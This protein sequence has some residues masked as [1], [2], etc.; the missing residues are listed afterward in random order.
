MDTSVGADQQRRWV[1]FAGLA[2]TVTERL[3]LEGSDAANKRASLHPP[4]TVLATS[5]HVHG[6][7]CA[8]VDPTIEDRPSAFVRTAWDKS[9]ADHIRKMMWDVREAGGAASKL[10]H[11]LDMAHSYISA[12]KA[13]RSE[14][15]DENWQAYH[16]IIAADLPN[17]DWQICEGCDEDED[18]MGEKIA[19]DELGA[20]LANNCSVVGL[21]CKGLL[22]KWNEVAAPEVEWR[23]RGEAMREVLRVI[24]R[25]W[26]E[27]TD[28]VRANAASAAHRM[29]RAKEGSGEYVLAKRLRIIDIDRT[30]ELWNKPEALWVRFLFKWIRLVKARVLRKAK[31]SSEP[32][33]ST[34]A[35]WKL[36]NLSLNVAWEE[37]T[38]N[39]MSE[40]VEARDE[41]AYTREGKG[42]ERWHGAQAKR[43]KER[44]S[45]DVVSGGG[46][47]MAEAAEGGGRSEP[48][49]E[50]IE[51]GG[52]R[53]GSGDNNDGGGPFPFSFTQSV[54]HA[55]GGSDGE[56]GSAHNNGDDEG[57]NN[58]RKRSSGADQTSEVGDSEDIRPAQTRR[59]DSMLALRP[60]TRADFLLHVDDRNSQTTRLDHARRARGDG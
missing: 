28:G 17:T 29:E 45:V 18:G 31:E 55:D 11:H 3:M 38:A 47:E 56:S 60:M 9:A 16:K 10:M 25:S 5:R 19:R 40:E 32:F 1:G 7:E 4:A 35:A 22:D 33:R 37:R 8:G 49:E 52:A 14:Q 41:R 21:C 48:E 27:M 50:E 43:R 24:V 57:H 30:T 39:G 13:A 58:K 44:T 23:E 15:P 51:M 53:S 20:K 42:Q 46:D 12:S 54:V 34:H 59:L 2:Q 6:G 26:R 36:R